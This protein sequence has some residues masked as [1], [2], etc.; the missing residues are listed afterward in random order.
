GVVRRLRWRWSRARLPETGIDY[1]IGQIDQKIDDDGDRAIGEDRSLNDRIVAVRHSLEEQVSKTR[2]I[3]D[4]LDDDGAGKKVSEL[5]PKQG[6]DR[7]KCVLE[8]MAGINSGRGNTPR[9]G[10]T[11]KV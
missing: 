7:D 4:A 3:E 10:S 9:P 1:A 8:P 5:R 11:N 2:N 6:D